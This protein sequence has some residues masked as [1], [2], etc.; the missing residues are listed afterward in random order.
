MHTDTH[1]LTDTH[2]HIPQNSKILLS[3]RQCE[4]QT[5]FQLEQSACVLQHVKINTVFFCLLRMKHTMV[6]MLVRCRIFNT[7]FRLPHF[8]CVCKNKEKENF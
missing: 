7:L 4:C 1:A 5:V 8:Y 2:I 3:N 6:L